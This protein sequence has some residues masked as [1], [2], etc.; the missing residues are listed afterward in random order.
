MKL[1]NLKKKKK[2]VSFWSLW[3]WGRFS[4]TQR[5]P[6]F[7]VIP[8][9]I[10]HVAAWKCDSYIVVGVEHAGNVLRQISVQNSLDVIAHVDYKKVQRAFLMMIILQHWV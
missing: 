1:L 6:F 9:Y 5:E 3:S 10:V 7:C 2:K 4:V 8:I